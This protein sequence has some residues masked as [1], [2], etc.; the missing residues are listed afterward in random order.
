MAKNR[1]SDEGGERL[2]T[3]KR[4]GE[5]SVRFLAGGEA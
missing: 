4:F 3:N 5:K 1:S 2:M